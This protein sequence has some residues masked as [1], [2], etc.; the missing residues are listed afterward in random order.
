VLKGN[1]D[2]VKEKANISDFFE[3]QL[4][5]EVEKEQINNQ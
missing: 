3:R 2:A 5:D 4:I 1:L